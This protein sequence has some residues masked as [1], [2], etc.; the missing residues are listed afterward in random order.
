MSQKKGIYLKTETTRKLRERVRMCDSVCEREREREREE[1][2]RGNERE[3][4]GEG[5]SFG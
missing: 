4:G 3:R 5:F 2:G 1:R